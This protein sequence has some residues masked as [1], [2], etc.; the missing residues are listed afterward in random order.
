M[1]FYNVFG[2]AG[3]YVDIKGI[4]RIYRYDRAVFAEAVTARLNQLNR[5]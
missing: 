5:R 2:V 3:L 1:L 4:F